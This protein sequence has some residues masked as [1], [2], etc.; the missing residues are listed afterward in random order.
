MA[1]K[2]ILAAVMT[3]EHDEAALTA[4]EMI[5]AQFEAH[6][7]ALV[8]AVHPASEFFP[9]P[10]PLS[11][12]LEDLIAGDKGRAARERERIVDWI[13]R[14]SVRFETRDVL[15][16]GALNQRQVLAHARRADL[17]VLTRPP[18]PQRAHEA[19][20]EHVL[21]GSGRPVLAMPS[22]WRRDALWDRILIGWDAGR[23]ASRAV[24]DSM[25]FLKLARHVV[26]AT[27]DAL[28]SQGGH[29][30]APGRDLAAHLAR[31]GVR[32][33]VSNI[34][35]L[36]RSE[37][38]ALIDQALAMDADMIVMGGYGHS[39]ASEYIFGGVTRELTATPHIPL[40]LSH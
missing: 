9:E 11:K 12:V 4:T 3:L 29:G 35:G 7:A 32:V 2:D 16:E 17:T 22:A 6:A 1:L 27:V 15:V 40:F 21:F 34:D 8:V 31:H 39:R 33:E 10:A 23:E 19:L 5:A 26:V 28:P 36:G 20:F 18:A 37:G 25:P 14:A 38:A 30:P 24:A 13:E